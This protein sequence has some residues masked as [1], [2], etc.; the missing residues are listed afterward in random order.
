MVRYSTDGIVN[1]NKRVFKMASKQTTEDLRQI[2]FDCIEKVKD[3]SMGSSE[4]KAVTSLADKII[5]S[6]KLE[7]EYAQTVSRLD[8]ED[9]GINPGPLMLT[10]KKLD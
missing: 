5:Q 3:G 1:R 7:L 4:A 6:A 9:Q 10:N 2:L 8:K